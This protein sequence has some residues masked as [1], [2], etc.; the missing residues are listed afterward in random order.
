MNAAAA[1]KEAAAI[2]FAQ[3]APFIRKKQPFVGR[4][5]RSGIPSSIIVPSNSS[6]E[7]GTM[8]Y[9]TEVARSASK[10]ISALSADVRS[11]ADAKL[12]QLRIEAESS[13]RGEAGDA[14]EERLEALQS[15]VTSLCSGLD[16]LSAV[17]NA[18]IRKLEEIDRLT[19][20]LI[21]W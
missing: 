9:D 1:P 11:A 13:L 19:R 5:L 2:V 18:Y 10:K 4:L 16:Q 7:A 21:G 6:K 17:L 8:K 12:R 14:L 15:D 3:S 20:Q